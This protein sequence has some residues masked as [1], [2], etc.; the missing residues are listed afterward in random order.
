[1]SELTRQEEDQRIRQATRRMRYIEELDRRF[2]LIEGYIIRAEYARA[3]GRLDDA[4]ALDNSVLAQRDSL[5]FYI[6][7]E[8]DTALALPHK[9]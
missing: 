3:D 1:M 5:V 9:V 6:C 2:H 7:N 4:H 8:V